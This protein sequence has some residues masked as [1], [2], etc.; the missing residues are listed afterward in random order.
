MLL[1]GDNAAPA[2]ERTV[3]AGRSPALKSRRVTLPGTAL[4]EKKKKTPG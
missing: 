1:S 4:G 3:A 2:S